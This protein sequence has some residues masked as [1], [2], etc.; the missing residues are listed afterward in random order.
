[1]RVDRFHASA[2][3]KVPEHDA[4]GAVGHALSSLRPAHAHKKRVHVLIDTSFHELLADV[5]PLLQGLMRLI[6]PEKLANR[7]NTPRFRGLYDHAPLIEVLQ[8]LRDVECAHLADAAADAPEEEDDAEIP[9]LLELSVLLAELNNLPNVG[10]V[11]HPRDLI[12]ARDY[13][14]ELVIDHIEPHLPRVFEQVSSGDALA[15]EAVRAPSE[16]EHVAKVTR[17]LRLD[18]LLHMRI[19]EVQAHQKKVL[20]VPLYSS[21]RIPTLVT[22]AAPVLISFDDF[23]HQHTQK[24]HRYYSMDRFVRPSPV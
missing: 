14:D 1:M 21:L 10:I 17:D 16:I 13:L 24:A 19:P 5:E 8:E 7:P 6:I 22:Q 23:R 9:N 4:D 15:H 18:H 3:G 2:L 11:G 12:F 20:L